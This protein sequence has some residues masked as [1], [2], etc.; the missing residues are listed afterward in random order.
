MCVSNGMINGRV[1]EAG[2]VTSPNYPLSYDKD[3]SCSQQIMGSQGQV[4]RI[5]LLDIQLEDHPHPAL[6]TCYDQLVLMQ[7]DSQGVEAK[8]YCQSGPNSLDEISTR[9]N[10]N[11]TRNE[12]IEASFES[13][14]R[15]H[16]RGFLFK[17]EGIVWLIFQIAT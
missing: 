4:I 13:T 14:S 3:Q 5:S 2:F 6:S 9:V 11:L 1:M 7:R 12:Y 15:G 10:F 16:N 8:T 17:Y